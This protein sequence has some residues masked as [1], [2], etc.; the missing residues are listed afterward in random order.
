VVVDHVECF[1]IGLPCEKDEKW[2]NA[3]ISIIVKPW[4]FII[5][6]EMLQP[7]DV[8]VGEDLHELIA[9]LRTAF[10]VFQFQRAEAAAVGGGQAGKFEELCT[11]G[12]CRVANLL[13]LEILKVGAFYD[14]L[15]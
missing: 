13:D 4:K 10:C 15:T 9:F 12:F 6:S 7:V 5:N 8:I 1:E 11:V 2:G 14:E 3:T